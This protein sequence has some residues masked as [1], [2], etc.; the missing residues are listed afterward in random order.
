M[1]CVIQDYLDYLRRNIEEQLEGDDTDDK[2]TQP[3]RL[4]EVFYLAG[5]IQQGLLQGK[6]TQNNLDQVEIWEQELDRT[7]L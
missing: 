2:F 3:L 1:I 4:A 5:W 6:V 7:N